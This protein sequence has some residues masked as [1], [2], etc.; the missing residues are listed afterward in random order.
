MMQTPDLWCG[1]FRPHSSGASFRSPIKVFRHWRSRF[2]TAAARDSKSCTCY[3]L[4]R[5][6]S[7]TRLAGVVKFTSLFH[8]GPHPW[9]SFRGYNQSRTARLQHSSMPSSQGSYCEDACRGYHREPESEN[10]CRKA[11]QAS[12]PRSWLRG[13]TLH[14]W[15]H[16][17]LSGGLCGI[18]DASISSNAHYYMDIVHIFTEN[19]SIS[20]EGLI[21]G[22]AR[23]H[24]N[25]VEASWWTYRDALS[26]L[27]R[28]PWNLLQ[29]WRHRLR[30]ENAHMPHR[31]S[32][33]PSVV[34]AEDDYG[35]APQKLRIPSSA[36]RHCP[37]SAKGIVG[38]RFDY[39]YFKGGIGCSRGC[40]IICPAKNFMVQCSQLQTMLE[41][42]IGQ[43]WTTV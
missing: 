17:N 1:A 6:P 41:I 3:W 16:T 5:V 13:K 36:C 15:A 21:R 26:L 24:I 38:P 34:D 33:D 43:D 40:Q 12:A 19:V 27:L 18:A 32:A 8:L 20:D 10:S 29:W 14:L 11:G 28:N 42:R 9:R 30:A 4:G 31:L 2:S 25:E 23:G 22:L 39:A 35:F 37:R 7:P